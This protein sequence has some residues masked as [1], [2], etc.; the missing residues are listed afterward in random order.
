MYTLE[1]MIADFTKHAE[2]AE[3]NN[4]E[5]IKSF[6]NNHP[7]EP[8]PDHLKEEFNLPKALASIC[9]EII[10]LKK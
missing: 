3:K 4:Q 1:E 5:W 7:G 6:Q 2:Q 8:L 9:S 10:K